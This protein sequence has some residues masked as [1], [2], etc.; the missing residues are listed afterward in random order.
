MDSWYYF[1]RIYL[2]AGDIDI[3][4]FK[5][6]KKLKKLVKV[7]RYIGISLYGEHFRIL[8]GY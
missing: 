4:I 3:L 8:E 1:T 6:K 5:M 2:S 7:C